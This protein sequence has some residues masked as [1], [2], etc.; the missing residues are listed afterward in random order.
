MKRKRY[1]EEKI[2]AMLKE[3]DAGVSVPELS[4]RHGVAENTLYRWQSKFG[5]MEVSG[6]RR[7]REPEAENAKL[8]RLLAES[9]LDNAALQERV[10]GK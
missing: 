1:P 4:R 7:L 5:G 8:K 6:A 9:M 10:R 3:V 2:M